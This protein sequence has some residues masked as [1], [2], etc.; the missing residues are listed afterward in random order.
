MS[1]SCSVHHSHQLAASQSTDNTHTT[2]HPLHSDSP[3]ASLAAVLCGI[4]VGTDPQ[5]C[6]RVYAPL[7]CGDNCIFI[8]PCFI[9][10]L[11]LPHEVCRPGQVF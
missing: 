10:H 5:S 3:C 6:N 9:M 1:A 8:C 2:G 7:F 4:A 11:A